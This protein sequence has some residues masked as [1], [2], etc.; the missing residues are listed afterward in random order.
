MIESLLVILLASLVF[1]AVFQYAHLF[2]CKAILSHAATRAARA[3]TV[4]FN[5]WMVRKS[6]LVAAIPASGR[7]LSPSYSDMSG[8]YIA[9][10]AR[11]DPGTV[12]NIALRAT[13]RS[14]SY[15]LEVGR[16]PE[17]MESINDPSSQTILDYEYWDR[18]EVDIHE[19]PAFDGTSPGTLTV[20][21]RQRHPLL[22]GLDSL[23]EG[24][25]RS[26]NENAEGSNAA[27]ED[28]AIA[29]EYSIESH[30]PLYLE[31]AQW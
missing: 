14:Q 8:A 30:Y 11:R 15:A 31:D 27:E 6:A 1:F 23:E 3:R 4:G 29:G 24:E 20:R 21:V 16:I 7:R 9:A 17:F 26:V 10:I 19:R 12:F 25:L 22:I 2:A 13:H 5:E 18:T 28:L